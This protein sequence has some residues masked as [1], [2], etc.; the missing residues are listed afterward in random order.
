[1]V[2]PSVYKFSHHGSSALYSGSPTY[3]KRC[4]RTLERPSA[5][6]RHPSA[7]VDALWG[8]RPHGGSKARWSSA[9]YSG[10]PTSRKRCEQDYAQKSMVHGSATM[11]FVLLAGNQHVLISAECGVIRKLEVPLLELDA[12]NV[13]ARPV[14]KMD[15]TKSDSKL[16][17][18]TLGG[19]IS[20]RS[21]VDVY[22]GA[23][24]HAIT[25]V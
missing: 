9:L 8:T 22:K 11:F 23:A 4:L 16:F 10:A 15:H 5:A 19:V 21:T 13:R 24:A 14:W 20:G 2:K 3:L 17:S 1:M 25:L 18:I 12:Y 7:P 6:P